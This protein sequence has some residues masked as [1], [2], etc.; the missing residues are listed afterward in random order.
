M[1][2]QEI[3][4]EF[5]RRYQD[6][7]IWVRMPEDVEESMFYVEKVTYD[8]ERLAVLS[9][10]SPEFG[11]IV[12]NMATTHKLKFKYPPVG[13]YQHGK[14]AYV[15]RRSPAKQYKHGIYAGNSLMY[16]V[17]ADLIG[18]NHRRDNLNFEEV[19]AAY[20]AKAYAFSAALT[21]LKSGKYRS[22]ALRDN[23]ALVLSMTA[24]EGYTLMYWETP[25]AMVDT[26][27]KV[28]HVYEASFNNVV[29]AVKGR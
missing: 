28:T 17:Y 7:F 5:A 15:F 27:G 25:V 11:R 26:E 20:K 19:A 22:V 3:I 4:Q 2:Q 23:Y 9:L 24:S 14:D 16:P 18:Q 6:S 1:N 21:M 8:E 10:T 13:V 29:E 12:I